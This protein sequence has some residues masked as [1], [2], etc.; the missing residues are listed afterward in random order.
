VSVVLIEFKFIRTLK[1]KYKSE[2]SEQLF[3]L[4]EGV[5]VSGMG[6][7]MHMFILVRFQDILLNNN[8]INGKLSPNSFV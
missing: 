3:N 2:H 8:R 4:P 5:P 1:T 6:E 7:N